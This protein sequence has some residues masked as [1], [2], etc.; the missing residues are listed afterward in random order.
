MAMNRCSAFPKAPALLECHNQ[1]VPC[2]IQDTRSGET[3][4][5]AEIQSVYSAA[6][7]ECFCFDFVYNF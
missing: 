3:Y 5:S 2:H 7:A 1:I 6:Q 4:F